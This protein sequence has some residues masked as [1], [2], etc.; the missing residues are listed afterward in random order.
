MRSMRIPFRAAVAASMLAFAVA[1]GGDDGSAADE[2]TIGGDATGGAGDMGTGTGTSGPGTEM[3]PV[4]AGAG[5]TVDTAA[6]DTTT[7]GSTA[8]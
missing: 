6:L 1:C 3:P 4:G 8:P 5:T 2:N 7:P